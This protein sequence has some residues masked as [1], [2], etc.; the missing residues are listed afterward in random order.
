[1][2]RALSTF[3]TLLL[4]LGPFVALLSVES[5][6]RLPICCRRHGSHHC[7]MNTAAAVN[8]VGNSVPALTTPAHCPL[9]PQGVASMGATKALAAPWTPSPAFHIS[10]RLY[11]SHCVA[12]LDTRLRAAS[13][14]APP[15]SASLA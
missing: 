9:F 10:T 7:S 14:R 2:R 12:P 15:A 1:M 11:V 8:A 5:E 3:L 6:S 13:S 4:S